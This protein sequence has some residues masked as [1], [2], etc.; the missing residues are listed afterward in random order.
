MFKFDFHI[1]DAADDL[2]DIFS[3][4]KIHSLASDKPSP[5]LEP[6]TEILIDHLVRVN[7]IQIIHQRLIGIAMPPS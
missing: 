1:D 6:F 4:S 2:E 5:D 7:F 3:A